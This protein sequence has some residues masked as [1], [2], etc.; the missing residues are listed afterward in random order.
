MRRRCAGLDCNSLGGVSGA[1]SRVFVAR[2]AGLAVFDPLGDQVGRVRDVIAVFRP[3]KIQP[4]RCRARRRGARPAPGVRADDPGDEHRR[5]AGHHDRPGQH[6]PVR[7]AGDRDAACSPSCSTARSRLRRSGDEV[8]SRT[9]RSSTAGRGEWRLTK[10]FRAP[11]AGRAGCAGAARPA[12]RHRRVDG[13]RRR[14]AARARRTCSPRSRAQGGRPGRYDPRAPPKRR[15]RGRGRPGRRAAGR[16]PGGAARGRPGR[17]PLPAR[18]S[19]P[20]TCSRRCSP[21]TR[22]TCS[23]TCRRR[24]GGAA[25]G[26]DGAGEAETSG[27]CSPTRSGRPAA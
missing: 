27:A 19:A 21:T 4:A 1:P 6:A 8:R 25:A 2:M 12:R 20:P 11:A 24:A 9:S 5:R 13:P 14:R 10:L 17:D 3:G 7:A 16:R 18:A 26:A 23:A 22:P 15:A